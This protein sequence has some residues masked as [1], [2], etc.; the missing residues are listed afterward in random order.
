M[1]TLSNSGIQLPHKIIALLFL[2]G[3]A[4]ISLQYIV[5]RQTVPYVGNS[6]LSTS[7]IVS[8]FLSAL[9]LGYFFG[10][11][12]KSSPQRLLS[13]NLMVCLFLYPIALS[14]L[15]VESFFSLLALPPLIELLLYCMV[16]LF[17][18]ALILSMTVPLTIAIAMN[19][20][21]SEKAG[22]TTSISTLG[23]VM[24]GLVSTFLL[25]YFFGVDGT[26]FVNYLFLVAAYLCVACKNIMLLILSLMLSIF[27]N[28]LVPYTNTLVSTQYADYR[29][30][31]INDEKYFMINDQYS[32]KI[33]LHGEKFDYI[34]LIKKRY[35]NESI[36]KVLVLGAGGFTV[37]DDI[38]EDIQFT[39]VDIDPKIKDIAEKRF[40]LKSVNGDF[41]AED[42]RSFINNTNE[43]YDLV[44][45]DLFSDSAAVPWHL[46]T[47]EFYSS[48]KSKIRQG[49]VVVIN[50]IQDLDMRSAFSRSILSTINASL[51]PCFSDRIQNRPGLGN[52]LY[53]CYPSKDANISLYSDDKTISSIDTA[54]AGGYR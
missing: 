43:Q 39:Y 3:F 22:L 28:G 50:I 13:R 24:G 20:R 48:I 25:M 2:E 7:L 29:V 26:V 27:L 17:P 14:K 49:G 12:V 4:S 15:F 34:E 10:G 47:T 16:A 5:I 44:V 32:S 35:L 33:G 37:S 1:T 38:K 45:V 54:L 31:I 9:A 51:G 52:V 46:L 21:S 6:V 19:A 36:D 53:S 23:N 18:M 40:L 30:K 8:M 11:K 42:A 41:K